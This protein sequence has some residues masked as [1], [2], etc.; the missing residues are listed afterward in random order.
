M[1]INSKKELKQI[2]KSEKEL[3]FN[4][5]GYQ[6][7]LKAIKLHPDYFTWKFVKQMRITSYYYS[8]RN[9]NIIYSVFYIM[10]SRKMNKL[11]RK[12]GIETGENVFDENV[13]IF[14]SNGIV[15][16]GNARIGKNC[17]LYGNN[18]IGNNGRNNQVPKLGDNVRVCVGAKVLGDVTIA[19]NITIAAGAVVTKSCLEENAILAG[20]PAKI[21]GY[22]N[23]D[24]KY[25][26]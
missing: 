18:C 19:N 20:I 15:I 13:R 6:L 25:L 16:N 22:N 11:A 9:N 5:G 14:H 4:K 17:R 24:K 10:N 12:I 26:D 8:K 2:I 1:E 3:Y 21:I 23:E 7:F